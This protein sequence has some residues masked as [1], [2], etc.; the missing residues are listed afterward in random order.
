MLGLRNI[1]WVKDRE[2]RKELKVLPDKADRLLEIDRALVS[3]KTCFKNQNIQDHPSISWCLIHAGFGS[4]PVPGSSRSSCLQEAAFRVGYLQVV[5]AQK[6]PYSVFCDCSCLYG[7]TEISP[8][9]ATTAQRLHFSCST[10]ADDDSARFL[11]G[12]ANSSGADDMKQAI[13]AL[14]ETLFDMWAGTVR[15]VLTATCW[16]DLLHLGQEAM[17]KRRTLHVLGLVDSAHCATSLKKFMY[18]C[19][20]T[21]LCSVSFLVG[22]S[23]ELFCA[24]LLLVNCLQD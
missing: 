18:V 16:E 12:G 11:R 21:W 6:G 14:E 3:S 20:V 9:W 19:R 13:D 5:Q 7:K 15:T 24:S 17:E 10:S 1:R 8:L 22:R 2:K 4:L 23:G